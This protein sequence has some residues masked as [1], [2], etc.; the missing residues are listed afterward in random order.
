[1]GA[2]AREGGEALA[3]L[4]EAISIIRR[5][6]NTAERG[7]HHEGEHYRLDGVKA[8]PPPAHDI[9]IWVGGYGPKMLRLIGRLV[10]GRVPTANKLTRDELVGKQRTLDEAVES[11]GRDPD[12]VRRVLNVGGLIT[13][14]ST[15]EWLTGPAEHWI[16]EL[17]TLAVD[18][19]FDTFVFWP[20]KTTTRS[21]VLSP[22]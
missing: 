8:G 21:C 14:G 20:T 16:D 11:A 1:M 17:T 5:F 13:D 3:A 9:G 12:A 4:E 10:D 6:C 18:D 19:G 22:R 15:R 7:I 2:P